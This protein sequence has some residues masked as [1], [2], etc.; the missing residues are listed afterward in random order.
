MYYFFVNYFSLNANSSSVS[1]IET[2]SNISSI[3][4]LEV[5]ENGN[6]INLIDGIYPVIVYKGTHILS[7]LTIWEV[8]RLTSVSQKR[9]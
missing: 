5:L 9:N 1:E 6:M 8:I 7:K 3:E 2:S 4:C